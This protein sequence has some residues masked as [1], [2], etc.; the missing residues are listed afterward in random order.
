MSEIIAQAVTAMNR[1]IE[2]RSFDYKVRFE[3]T[4]EGVFVADQN[5]ARAA[6]EPSDVTLK[7]KPKV[8]AAIADGSQNPAA[9]VM[10]GKLKIS[11]DMS[12]A[13]KIGA[14]FG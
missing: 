7:A 1:K 8:F 4:G 6:D 12:L 2:G 3:L 10:L 11:G 5:G 14:L 9:A 13:L